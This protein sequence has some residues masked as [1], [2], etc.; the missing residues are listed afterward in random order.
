[1]KLTEIV[2]A[3]F[4]L[5]EMLDFYKSVFSIPFNE[6]TIPQGK[7]YEANDD[8]LKIT[9]CPADIAGITAKDNRH[10]LTF[11]VP[12]INSCIRKTERFGGTLMNE[13]EETND[14]LQIAVRDVDNNS[15]VLKELR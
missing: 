7:I 10:Q 12:D 15:I 3:C 8:D 6:V 14:C 11:V 2:I 5:E 1:M 9:L 13:L 4:K